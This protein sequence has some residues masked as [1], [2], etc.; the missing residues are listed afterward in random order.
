M[1]ARLITARPEAYSNGNQ[2]LDTGC[3]FL[4]WSRKRVHARVC[5]SNPS[6]VV[7]YM[8]MVC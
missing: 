7:L 5:A 8:L 4:L 1:S 3:F 2:G 6:P